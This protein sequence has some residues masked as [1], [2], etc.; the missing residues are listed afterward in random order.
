MLIQNGKVQESKETIKQQEDFFFSKMSKE[1][2]EEMGFWNLLPIGDRTRKSW[3]GP[4][5]FMKPY[6]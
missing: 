4:V 2:E 1:N 3:S 6:L 5:D